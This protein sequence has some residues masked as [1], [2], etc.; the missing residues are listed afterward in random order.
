MAGSA[1]D[2]RNRL[3][4]MI[5]I[6]RAI[7]VR[8]GLRLYT[9]AVRTVVWSGGR[10]GLGTK[11]TVDTGLKLDLGIGS[12]RVRQIRQDE[13][14]ASGGLYQ[15]EDMVIGPITPPYAGSSADNDAVSVFE[16]PVDGSA[17]EIYF[18]LTGPGMPD[19]GA[20]FKKVSQDVSKSFRYTFVVS[21]T[22]V[23]P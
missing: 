15:S 18:K 8:A 5:D 7:P 17:R 19:T 11:T 21:K 20:W 12:P 14:V 6:L 1:T 22:S 10:P 13:V 2:L 23:V 3:L 4:P 16:P 9:V